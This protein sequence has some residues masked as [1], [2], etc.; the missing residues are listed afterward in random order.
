MSLKDGDL[1]G[2]APC[3]AHLLS[4]SGISVRIYK[5]LLALISFQMLSDHSVS[6]QG[7]ILLLL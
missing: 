1:L 3:V 7:K 5:I 4:Y 6:L 2:L